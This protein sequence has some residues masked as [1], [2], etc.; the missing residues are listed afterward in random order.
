M[1]L[2]M[3]VYEVGSVTYCTNVPKNYVPSDEDADYVAGQV[4]RLF[5]EKVSASEF[6][7]EID[8]LDVTYGVGCI[9]TTITLGASVTAIYRFIKNYPKFRPGLM[10][11]L[12]DI[13]GFLAH[14]RGSEAKGS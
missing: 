9:V 8:V 6:A 13:N 2:D 4:E 12:K 1:E 11:L 3:E 10:L 5:R 7:D 14:L